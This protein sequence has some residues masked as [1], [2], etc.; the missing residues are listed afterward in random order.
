MSYMKICLENEHIHICIERAKL[1]IKDPFPVSLK[2]FSQ[3]SR[4]WAQNLVG[5]DCVFVL[6]GEARGV[7]LPDLPNQLSCLQETPEEPRKLCEATL[8]WIPGS[9]TGVTASSL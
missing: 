9:G 3:W 1:K 4:G 7:N 8:T 5:S 2:D 6:E